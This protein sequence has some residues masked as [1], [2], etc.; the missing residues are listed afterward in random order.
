MLLIDSDSSR[1]WDLRDRAKAALDERQGNAWLDEAQQKLD[2]GDLDTAAELAQRAL[3]VNAASL[4]APSL[5]RRVDDARHE[6]AREQER[7]QRCRAAVDRARNRFDEGQFEDA[8]VAAE[9]ALAIDPDQPDALSVKH[10]ALDAVAAAVRRRELEAQRAKDALAE[11]DRLVRSG[12]A[13]AALTLLDSYDPPHADI[14]AARDALRAEIEA[15]RRE[16]ARRREEALRAEAERLERQ[17]RTAAA[18]ER[19]AVALRGQNFTAALE[20]LH[21][22]ENSDP[23]APNLQ[24]LIADADA[25]KAAVERA[26]QIAIDVRRHLDA[27]SERLASSDF[28][29]AGAEIQA[30]LALDADDAE[31]Q[32]LASR[33]EAVAR[34]AA[35]QREREAALKREREQAFAAAM[36]RARDAADHEAAIA[37]VREALSID[38]NDAAARRLLDEHQRALDQER[39]VAEALARAAD[40]TSTAAAIAALQQALQI[41]PAH[42]EA[43]KRLE[44]READLAREQAEAREKREREEAAARQKR[45]REEAEARQKR[46]REAAAARQQREREEEEARLQRERAAAEARQQRERDEAIAAAI[47]SAAKAPTHALALASLQTALD[48]DPTHAEA[49]RL[50][51]ARQTALQQEEAAE[52]R[53]HQIEAACAEI[54]EQIAKGAFDA[55]ERTIATFEHDADAKKLMKGLRRR[56]KDARAAALKRAAEPTVLIAVPDATLDRVG[57]GIEGRRRARRRRGYAPGRWHAIATH[58]RG[59]RRRNRDVGDRGISDDASARVATGR[60]RRCNLRISR[61]AVGHA[62]GGVHASRGTCRRQPDVG[63]DRT[64]HRAS[65]WKP[66]PGRGHT[67]TA[68][69]R[70]CSSDAGGDSVSGRGCGKPGGAAPSSRSSTARGRNVPSRRSLRQCRA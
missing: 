61:A 44:Q 4:R 12:D 53:R 46:E 62:A 38:A 68:D 18:I 49:Q 35:E 26:R 1:A 34:A 21:A 55:A 14:A 22:L 63:A 20:I 9:Q 23:D 67:V 11:A 3:E 31:A 19:A 39:R 25:Q 70:R 66:G 16:E 50:F 7:L 40:A 13:G 56:L 36:A 30:A 58:L 45:E 69:R 15:Q 51:T 17:R 52:R 8:V 33:I 47:R 28:A 65:A 27:A 48:I 32:S 29:A 24:A 64:R 37:A 43:R 41:A 5:L 42:P 57:G 10:K 59:R 6:R 54:D 60:R 2:R